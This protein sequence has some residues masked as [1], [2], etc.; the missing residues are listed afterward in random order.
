MSAP[1]PVELGAAADNVF[2]LA[3]ALLTI[4]NADNSDASE[5][6]KATARDRLTYRLFLQSQELRN[7]VETGSIHGAEPVAAAATGGAA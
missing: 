2:A 6:E 1:C 3:Y 7:L 4:E 5:S